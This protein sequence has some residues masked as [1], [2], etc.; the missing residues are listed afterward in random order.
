MNYKENSERQ[1]ALI[2][3]RSNS[4]SAVTIRRYLNICYWL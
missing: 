2:C 4:M 3:R 1:L